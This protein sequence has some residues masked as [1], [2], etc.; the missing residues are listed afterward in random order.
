MH[1]TRVTKE[2]GIRNIRYVVRLF[3]S[4]SQRNIKISCVT[5]LL[6]DGVGNQSAPGVSEEWDAV[7][8]SKTSPSESSRI[9]V[10]DDQNWLS[11]SGDIIN[12]FKGE[13]GWYGYKFSVDRFLASVPV[14]K[15][16][17]VLL[18]FKYFY[19]KFLKN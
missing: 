16:F 4:H 13:S 9:V 12:R 17:T 10:E 19:N 3:N 15:V 18:V 1:N 11:L 5:L 7:C 14:T 8:L 2:N 6:W